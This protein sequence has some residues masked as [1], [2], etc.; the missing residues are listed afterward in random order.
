VFY[1]TLFV[2][3]CVPCTR[4]RCKGTRADRRAASHGAYCEGIHSECRIARDRLGALRLDEGKHDAGRYRNQQRSAE[5]GFVTSSTHGGAA[6]ERM[7]APGADGSQRQRGGGDECSCWRAYARALARWSLYFR[8]TTAR[9]R[10]FA[11]NGGITPAICRTPAGNDYGYQL[12]FFR[13]ALAPQMAQRTST[14]ATNQ[15]YMAHF[16]LTD[17]ARD[18]HESF[19]RYS[20]GAG[21]LAGAQRRANL[22]GVVGGLVGRRDG[23]GGG[24]SCRPAQTGQEGPVAIDL[25]LRQTRPPVLQ[26]ECRIGPEGARA[27]QRFVLL[28]PH[29]LGDER[30]HYQCGPAPS[31]QRIQLAG[32][33]VWHQRTQPNAAGLGLVQPATRQRRSA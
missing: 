12:T 8:A 7:H 33:R 26:G 25:T 19:E 13:S 2:N 3:A 21:G 6:A 5:A 20:R 23:A 14:L 4:L 29:R 32:P 27:G 22:S 11:A 30:P 1:H 18:E 31:G 15:V 16:A 28:Q 10:I 9:I 24:C 17:G